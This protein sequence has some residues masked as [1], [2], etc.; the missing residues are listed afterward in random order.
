MSFELPAEVVQTGMDTGEHSCAV[1][2]QATKTNIDAKVDWSCLRLLY[3]PGELVLVRAG[4]VPEGTS[5]Y[6]GPL[7]VER[8]LGH[9]TFMLSDGQR[10]STCRMK[11][12]Y[13]PLPTTYREPATNVQEEP[14]ILR[15][16]SRLNIGIPPARYPL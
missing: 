15:R 14:P 7:K 4:P 16:S 1:L 13:E 10:W 5:L 6:K 11:W 9:Y 8:V 3:K 12:W 2:R